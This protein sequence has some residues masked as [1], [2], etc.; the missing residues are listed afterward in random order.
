MG[1]CLL[2]GQ[3][4]DEH[5]RRGQRQDD[6]REEVEVARVQAQRPEQVED[7]DDRRPEQLVQRLAE[8]DPLHGRTPLA[9]ARPV[10]SRAAA[11]QV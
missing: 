2:V 4:D 11:R 8:E 6:D 7:R 3:D 5:G 9:G 10:A 1:S